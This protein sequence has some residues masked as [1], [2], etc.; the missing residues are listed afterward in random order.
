MVGL[1]CPVLV[2]KLTRVEWNLRGGG[3]RVSYDSNAIL[4]VCRHTT[5][6]RCKENTLIIEDGCSV[7]FS[8]INRRGA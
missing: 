8:V 1:E 7:R 6:G 4:A 2:Q 5:P 3:G